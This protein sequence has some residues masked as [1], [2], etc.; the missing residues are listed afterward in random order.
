MHS[1]VALHTLAHTPWAVTLSCTYLH[2]PHAHKIVAKML[3]K[4]VAQMLKS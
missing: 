2:T 3:K 1:D 4:M